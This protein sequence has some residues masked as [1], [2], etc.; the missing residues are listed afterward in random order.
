MADAK[1]EE[2][3]APAREM[4]EYAKAGREG[5]IEDYGKAAMQERSCNDIFF[6]ILFILFWGG[7]IVVAVFAFQSGDP[8]RCV[9]LDCWHCF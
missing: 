8:R 3:D 9:L 6:C 7:M 5:R 1:K 4:P 2:T